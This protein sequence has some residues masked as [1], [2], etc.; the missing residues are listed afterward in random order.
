ML[1]NCAKMKNKMKWHAIKSNRENVHNI[2]AMATASATPSAAAVA[3]LVSI[4]MRRD[5]LWRQRSNNNKIIQ[6]GLMHGNDRWIH[7]GSEHYVHIGIAVSRALGF[8]LHKIIYSWIDKT[9]AIQI[10]FILFI[11][12]VCHNE[13]NDTQSIPNIHIEYTRTPN[14][15]SANKLFSQHNCTWEIEL[16][17][18]MQNEKFKALDTPEVWSMFWCRCVRACAFVATLFLSA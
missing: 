16:D 10:L 9:K 12:F 1:F 13:N 18:E 17:I 3:T 4:Q 6:N 14:I 5:M 15:S 7:N 11:F 2:A 8:R